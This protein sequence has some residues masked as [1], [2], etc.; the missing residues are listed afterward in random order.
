MTLLRLD[1]WI[2]LIQTNSWAASLTALFF[3]SRYAMS[4]G[5]TALP[6]PSTKTV[7]ERLLAYQ[8]RH[9]PHPTEPEP[10][11]TR[12]L[13]AGFLLPI[14]VTVGYLQVLTTSLLDLHLALKECSWHVGL[15]S[16]FCHTIYSL[17]LTLRLMNVASVP[18]V[19]QLYVVN[20][21]A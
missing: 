8:P 21:W 15:R 7:P 4:H 10:S 14:A 6:S 16:L 5:R 11:A 1:R 13:I 2:R 18:T 20:M 3:L 19:Y 12:L 17:L 9:V